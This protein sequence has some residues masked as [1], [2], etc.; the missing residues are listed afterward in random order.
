MFSELCDYQPP[1]SSHWHGREDSLKDERFFQ[2]V[3]CFDIRTELPTDSTNTI[4]LGFCSDEGIRRNLGRLGARFGPDKIRLLLGKLACHHDNAYLDIGNIVCHETNLERAQKQLSMVID[5]CH[6]NGHKTVI[7]GGGHEIAWP[8]YQGLISQCNQ[9]GIINFDAHFDLRIP[10]EHQ[11][12]SGTPFWQI[13][14]HCDENNTS[15][16][17]CCLGIQ[18]SSNTA[19]LFKR[20]HDNN[21][22]YLTA[23]QIHKESFAWQVAFLDDFILRHD[24]LYVSICLDVFADCFA[25]GVSAPQALGLTPWQVLMLLK[26]IMQSGKV[27]SLDIAELSPP[28]DQDDK[29]ARLAAALLAEVLNLTIEGTY[30]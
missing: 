22:I 19:S 30:V 14:L 7:F 6:Q 28:L 10:H 25:P 21:V 26:Y 29:T 23:E 2:R 12:S 16:N 9:L 15:F 13:K 8:H 18:P 11:A 1:N 17:Y 24:N 3:Q 20:A 5:Y 4:F 27:I